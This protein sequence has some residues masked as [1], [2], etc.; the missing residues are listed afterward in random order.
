MVRLIVCPRDGPRW[1]GSAASFG[2]K[3]IQLEGLAPIELAEE[4]QTF[5]CVHSRYDGFR[6]W[7]D[8]IDPRHDPRAAAY[9]RSA[10]NEAI[11][12]DDLDRPGLTAEE[13]AAYE[14]NY[15]QLVQ[16][17]GE[18]QPGDESHRN[19]LH[20]RRRNSWHIRMTSR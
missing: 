10:C 18:A 3:R 9:L 14:L 7:F 6:F 13:R 8:E 15:W 19:P 12:P 2:D 4:V 1:F 20:R 16:P 11:A 5:D 17:P